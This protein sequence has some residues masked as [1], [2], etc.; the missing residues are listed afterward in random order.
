MRDQFCGHCGE[1]V[2]QSGQICPNCGAFVE[3]QTNM[4]TLWLSITY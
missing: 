1:K 3:Y 4:F 2:M